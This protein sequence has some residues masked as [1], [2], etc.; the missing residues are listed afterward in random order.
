MPRPREKVRVGRPN[1]KSNVNTTR[2]VTKRHNRAT[3]SLTQLGRPGFAPLRHLAIFTQG[4]TTTSPLLAQH[5]HG[6]R[7]FQPPSDTSPPPVCSRPLWSEERHNKTISVLLRT[8]LNARS[9][10]FIQIVLTVA[11]CF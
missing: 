11:G 5:R 7:E 4:A 6:S 3:S 10:E 8:L 9:S 1:E 2:G